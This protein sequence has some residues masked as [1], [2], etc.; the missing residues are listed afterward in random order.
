MGRLREQSG[1]KIPDSSIFSDFPC[2]IPGPQG[3]LLDSHLRYVALPRE[4]SRL[5]PQ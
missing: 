1:L 5:F 3:P 4:V 2:M